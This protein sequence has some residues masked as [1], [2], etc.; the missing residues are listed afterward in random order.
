MT[1]S[2]CGR[3]IGLALFVVLLGISRAAVGQDAVEVQILRQE[4]VSFWLSKL[5]GGWQPLDDKARVALYLPAA[6]DPSAYLVG[7]SRPAAE[8]F[9]ATAKQVK[10]VADIE[11]TFADLYIIE[12]SSP[13]SDRLSEIV[14]RFFPKTTIY[15][16]G[17]A[18][19]SED[20]QIHAQVT[21]DFVEG[22]GTLLAVMK[23]QIVLTIA[24]AKGR[25]AVVIQANS[26]GQSKWPVS[27]SV[28]SAWQQIATSSLGEAF[29][30]LIQGISRNRPLKALLED[31]AKDRALPASLITTAQFNDKRALF[32][33]G[34]LEAGEAGALQI[35]VTN[36]GSGPA[37]D[38]AVRVTGD[39]PQV[40]ASGDGT[41]GDLRPGESKEIA[42][43]IAGSVDLPTTTARLR[44]ETTEKRGYGAQPVLFELPAEKLVAPRLEIVDV[45]LNDR[46]SGG[47][48]SGDGDG[49]PANGETLEA[50]VRVRNAGPGDAVGVTV[51]MTAPKAAAEILEAKAVIPRI[52]ANRV[53]EARL[54]FRLPLA[55][56]ASEL[57]SSFQAV[58]AR[59]PQVASVGK[60]QTWKIRTKLPGIELAYRVYDGSSTGSTGNRDGLVNNGERIEIG[61]TPTNR[62]DLPARGVKIAVEPADP[63]LV[64]RP[65]VLDVGDLPV[66]AEGTVQR[67]AFDVPRAYGAA[68]PGGDLRFTLNISQQSFPI[69]REPLTLTFR[70]LRPQLSLETSVPPALARGAAGELILRLRNTGTLRADEVVVEVAS[71][72]AGIDLLDERGVPVPSR[73]IAFG[74]LEPQGA[75]GEQRVGVQA[76][77][78]AALGQAPL[79]LTV[80][81]KDFASLIRDTALAVTE[82]RAAVIAAPV[83]EAPEPAPASAPAA[84]AAIAFLRNTQG[85]HLLSEAIVLRFEVQSPAEL[86]ELRVTQNERLLSI[87]TA[88]HT[89]NLVGGVQVTQ[90]EIPVQLEVGENRFEVVAVTRQG[91]RTARPLTL[92]R[93]PETGRIWVLAVGISRYQ[94]PEI[95][96]LQYADADAR[97]IYNYFRDTFG[98]PENQIFLRLNEQATLRE[99]KSVLGTLIAKANDPRDTVILYF[100][101]HGMRDRMAGSLD[102]DGLNKYFLPFDASRGELYSTALEMDEIT[103][104]LQRLRPDRVVVLLDTCFSGAAGG[105]SPFDPRF[106]GERALISSEFLDRMAH[107]GKGRVVLTAGGPEESA[108]E[109]ADLGHGVF[110]YYLLDGLH[111]AADLSGDGEIDVDEIYR[112]VSEKVP[113]ATQ[114]RQ[115]PKLKE[116]DLVGRILLGRGAARRRR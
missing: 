106:E 113:R 9:W 18:P 76:R 96:P 44:I 45:S 46:S 59:G 1:S 95:K 60:E 54:L 51:S 99:I 24:D 69:R 19:G 13:L 33:N 81:Q 61:V 41:V 57:S 109:S 77:R 90:Y 30:A 15:R 101:G 75:V 105:R 22:E 80:S 71:E 52:P 114:G 111:G 72:A 3:W 43:R 7:S 16:E 104:I 85:E 5:K 31:L 97:D 32:P 23:I 40:A 20:I 91:L 112:Y 115:N 21:S 26:R 87:D 62:G 65:A 55:L 73:K 29:D 10:E 102:P 92:I 88:W 107:I 86:A 14:H 12:L 82:E 4:T 25:Q 56:Q 11:A 17:D 98:L 50:I 34:R 67:F 47:R 78:N 83:R 103:G 89:A 53:E 6:Q 94:D 49:Q 38:V 2:R 39:P 8:R 58:D 93:D 108:Q 35:Q 27:W 116:P 48:T 28:K 42:L 79:H 63:K 66:Q 37:Y 110:T 64:P 74:A 84:T 100:A 70:N 36:R 68:S